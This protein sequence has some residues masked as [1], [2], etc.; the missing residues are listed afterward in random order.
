MQIGVAPSSNVGVRL[1][2]F[3]PVF[4]NQFRFRRNCPPTPLLIISQHFALS[5]KYKG[6]NVSLG[7][8]VGGQ[9]PSILFVFT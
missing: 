4:L 8:G 6:V 1:T 2:L 9:F 3:K 5:D 7:G